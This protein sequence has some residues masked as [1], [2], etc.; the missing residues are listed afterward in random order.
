MLYQM[1][2]HRGLDFYKSD[3]AQAGCAIRNLFPVEAMFWQ[4]CM[5]NND[6]EHADRI[7]RGC[8]IILTGRSLLFGSA[9]SLASFE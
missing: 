7:R 2:Q 9:V 6:H 4:L 8:T 3:I 5:C 1:Y